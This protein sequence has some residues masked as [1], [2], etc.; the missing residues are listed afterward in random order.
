MEIIM[1]NFDDNNVID[2]VR[3][4]LNEI[5]ITSGLSVERL[6]G[7]AYDSTKAYYVFKDLD[8]GTTYYSSAGSFTILKDVTPDY[9]NI[10]RCFTLNGVQPV[11]EL[12]IIQLE[13]ETDD[14]D[15]DEDEDEE[16]DLADEDVSS[17]YIEELLRDE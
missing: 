5:C 12:E 15:E 13:D 8:G 9:D 3:L 17:Q 11:L 10:E 2:E 14:E 16:E 1:I 6:I 4:H 7:Y